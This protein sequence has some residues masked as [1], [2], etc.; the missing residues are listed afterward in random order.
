MSYVYLKRIYILQL[1]D[2]VTYICLQYYSVFV[3]FLSSSPSVT[4]SA[5]LKYQ[6]YLFSPHLQLFLMVTLFPNVFLCSVV[7]RYKHI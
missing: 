7:I 5:E 2:D 1:L 4:E 6:L 3:W